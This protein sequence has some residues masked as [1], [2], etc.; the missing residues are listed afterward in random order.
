MAKSCLNYSE[1]EKLST[2]LVVEVF[3]F[4][5]KHIQS[6]DR[7]LV[8][9]SG[10]SASLF[11]LRK[12]SIQT[13]LQPNEKLICF[14]RSEFNEF[15]SFGVRDR[16][17]FQELE[18]LMVAGIELGPDFVVK[19]LSPNRRKRNRLSLDSNIYSVKVKSKS[20]QRSLTLKFYEHSQFRSPAFDATLEYCFNNAELKLHARVVKEPVEPDGSIYILSLIDLMLLK[21]FSSLAPVTQKVQKHNQMILE[22][23]QR[24]RLEKSNPNVLSYCFNTFKSFIEPK[25][26]NNHRLDLLKEIGLSPS[27]IHNLSI[28]YHF[29][30]DLFNEPHGKRN[31]YHNIWHTDY[32]LSYAI[33]FCKDF[34]PDYPFKEELCIAAIFHDCNLGLDDDKLAESVLQHLNSANFTVSK[35]DFNQFTEQIKQ[36][37]CLEEKAGQIAK[38]FCMNACGF[39][40]ERANIVADFIEYTQLGRHL[41]MGV[42]SD[43][44]NLGRAIIQMADL[45]QVTLGDFNLFLKNNWHLMYELNGEPHQWFESTTGML[46]QLTSSLEE[47]YFSY[48]L[49]NLNMLLFDFPGKDTFKKQLQEGLNKN[50]KLWLEKG[51]AKCLE[52]G[53]EI[54]NLSRRQLDQTSEDS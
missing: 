1:K 36:A 2:Q 3:Q 18:R 51:L 53:T 43:D 46:N 19:E 47:N 35:D 4:I 5:E 49:F 44:Q 48:P 32:V 52:W 24:F 27:Q 20:E 12:L 41:K 22:E 8:F 42:D 11:H 21:Y 50:H 14:L 54:A 31:T 6:E 10:N 28:S 26:I 9:L 34:F 38:I 30:N 17:V 25:I 39:D 16:W 29:V 13:N 23:L 40:A 45:F 33:N 37:S 15:I 7:R